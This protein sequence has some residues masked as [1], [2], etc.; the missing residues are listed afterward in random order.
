MIG[1]NTHIACGNAQTADEGHAETLAY[2]T[3]GCYEDVAATLEGVS[4]GL[5]MT[6][7]KA[8]S[9]VIVNRTKCG[10]HSFVLAS[11]VPPATTTARIAGWQRRITIIAMEPPHKA[12]TKE[13]FK[14]DLS[15][16][17]KLSGSRESTTQFAKDH[18]IKFA[19]SVTFAKDG[20]THCVCDLPPALAHKAR[21]NYGLLVMPLTA[22][23]GSGVSDKML[24]IDFRREVNAQQAHEIMRTLQRKFGGF[25]AISNF[26]GRLLLPAPPAADIIEEIENV[27][28]VRVVRRPFVA[29][30]NVTDE[31]D[32][33]EDVRVP[34]APTKGPCLLLAGSAF[35][36]PAWAAA[37]AKHIA[38]TVA[39][40]ATVTSCD[41]RSALIAVTAAQLRRFAG[42]TVNNGTMHLVDL[43]VAQGQRKE[44]QRMLQESLARASLS[45]PKSRSAAA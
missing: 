13:D 44:A 29:R 39:G 32:T 30:Q 33:A 34:V 41:G 38:E 37:V 5:R 27:E 31:D 7:L 14:I 42:T 16:V 28:G 35:V 1:K 20:Q 25:N 22:L 2:N 18:A 15:P 21:I 9:V 36:P 17:Y 4:T 12:E 24:S 43:S 3:F 19:H 40:A 11:G 10:L 6:M 23:S 45:H 8:K 26:R